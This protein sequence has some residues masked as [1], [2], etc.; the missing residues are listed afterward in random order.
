MV[1]AVLY[2]KLKE[3]AAREDVVHYHQVA[4]LVGLDMSLPEDCN[5]PESSETCW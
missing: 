2:V 4:P 3:V 5:R 1:N